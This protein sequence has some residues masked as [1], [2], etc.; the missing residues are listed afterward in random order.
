[1]PA[2]LGSFVLSG[3]YRV[4]S[5]EGQYRHR[6]DVCECDEITGQMTDNSPAAQD[7][8]TGG[9]RP[10]AKRPPSR[11]HIPRWLSVSVS[12]LI[13]A[14]TIWF[15]VIPQ[16]GDAKGAV[17]SLGSVALPLLVLAVILELASLM[18]YSA[19]TQLVLAR[20]KPSYATL[21]RIDLTDLGVNHV[22][23]GGGVTS[24][25]L[26]LRLFKL[27]G[28][29]AARGFTTATLE[30]TG[31]NLVLGAIF[32]VGIVFSL[33]SFSGNTLYSIAAGAVLGLLVA[34]GA[35]VWLLVKRTNLAVRWIRAVVHHLPF[36]TQAGAEAFV[37]AMAIQTRELGRDRHRIVW[38][39]LWA[40]ANWLLDA[41]ALWVL[42]AA[43]R[44][45]L[46][47]GAILTVYGLG[48]ILAALPLTPGGLG[49]VEGVMVPAFVAFGAPTQIAVLGVIGWRVLE[50]WMPI[51]LSL[52]AYTS[53]RLGP[54]RKSK[55][56]ATK[57]A[58]SPASTPPQRR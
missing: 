37:R 54:L 27:V 53:L 56:T 41:A 44:H 46:S 49:I 34:T 33:T 50:Y 55:T 28:I 45:V 18:S 11:V 12:V 14:L 24:G 16:F 4:D 26:R 43:F 31:S 1:V 5:P 13:L 17:K 7:A 29:P 23:P 36:I 19:L 52:A 15:V 10:V 8:A 47:L 30:I 42:F 2:Q 40:L 22:V 21:L 38:S 57:V 20:R 32:A 58:D 39:T 35:S 25:A 48:S 3:R 6:D 9:A 51:P